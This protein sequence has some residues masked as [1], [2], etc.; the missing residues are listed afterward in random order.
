MKTINSLLGPIFKELGIEDRLAI[1]S[2]RSEWKSIFN[3][4]LSLHTYPVEF[5][6]GDLLINVDSPVWLQQ[7]KFF[8]KDIIK[9]LSG[10][11]VKTVRFKS[12]KV[13]AKGER[14][15]GQGEKMKPPKVL[16]PSDIAWIEEI[17]SDLEDAEIRESARK[18]ISKQMQR[19]KARK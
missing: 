16:G 5:A 18:A 15:A 6:S 1:E 2:L 4:P 19:P 11:N 14:G 17:T 9:K 8:K 7:L 12:G 10:Y 3:E 13:Y